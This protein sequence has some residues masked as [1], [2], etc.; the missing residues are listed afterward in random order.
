MSV[1]HFLASRARNPPEGDKSLPLSLDMPYIFAL[2]VYLYFVKK[3]KC[4]V[5]DM[6]ELF[7]KNGRTIKVRD[8]F[9]D[10]KKKSFLSRTNSGV[11]GNDFTAHLIRV[12]CLSTLT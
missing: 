9:Y 7:F 4:A 12:I 2:L 10:I 6:K 5:N 8:L 11:G 3:K 1:I